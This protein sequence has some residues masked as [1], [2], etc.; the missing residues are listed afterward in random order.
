MSYVIINVCKLAPEVIALH[1]MRFNQPATAWKEGLPIGNGRLAAMI[2]GDKH[3]DVIALNHEWLW[4]GVNRD[5]KV[6]PNA[7]KLDYVRELLKDEKFFKATLFGNL[8]FG[9]DGGISGEQ[10]GVDPYQPAGDLIFSIDNCDSYVGRSLDIEHGSA[11]TSRLVEGC[12]VLSRFF[13]DCE[14]S[15]IY[16]SWHSQETFSGTLKLSRAADKYTKQVI[17]I[18]ANDSGKCII[19][20]GEFLNGISF[21]ITADIR[22]D[23]IFS[24]SE[25]NLK[26]ENA[27]WLKCIVNI[28][29]SVKG[30]KEELSIY[31]AEFDFEK[32]YT[33]HCDSFSQMFNR[34]SFEIKGDEEYNNYCMEDRIARIKKGKR[35]N[36]ISTLLYNFGRYL[37]IAS[38]ISGEL[39]PNL[40]GK[41]NDMAEPPW[42][43]DYHMNINL[44]MNHWLALPCQFNEGSLKF[45]TFLES[46]YDSAADAAKK[47][48]NCRGIYMPLQTDAWGISTPEAFGWAVWVGCAPWMA[49]HF[50]EHYTYNGDIG[51]LRNRAYPYFKKV[52]EFFEDYLVRDDNGVYQVMPSQS[53]ENRFQSSGLIPVSLCVSAAMDVQLCYD[54]FSYA[55]D[56]AQI[57]DIDLESVAIW[58]NIKNNLPKFGIGSD[59]RLLEWNDEKEEVQ[60]EL[61]HRHLSHLYG[62]YPSDL[63]TE[64]VRTAE[65]EASR[66]SFDFRL[67][68][69]G[70]H[71]GWSRAWVAALM[72][73]FN[74]P[75]GVY[76]HVTA[77]LVDFATVSLLD[78]H[79]PGWFQIDGNLGIVA[80]INDSLLS[81]TNDKIHVMRAVP[82]EWDCG[83][84]SGL[85]APGGHI[86]DLTWQNGK[87]ETLTIS[88][89]FAKKAVLVLSGEEKELTGFEGDIV[90]LRNTL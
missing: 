75:D 15:L 85:K 48:Y 29:T 6:V 58:K 36:G 88:I 60:E 19:L 35:D 64:N 13:A 87:M 67:K 30:I 55:I 12:N 14:S 62:V 33:M 81:F 54:A 5:R 63:F 74:N 61:G 76:E 51:F 21:C 3:K 31:T 84:I 82:K 90:V 49:R 45:L 4:R 59:G 89:G 73:R 72:S 57:L 9:G 46:F 47:L 25:S 16:C 42:D 80:A 26:I 44:Q 78:L 40:Q 86:I 50:W 28:A 68:H 17:K 41:W 34:T 38:T 7:D 39:P 24:D 43:S 18:S 77:L 83:S 27:T 56:A 79:P 69:G 10:A 37:F 23:G 53:P 1:I 8:Y 71:T 11:E 2:W 52:A 65:Y 66:K 32:V 20:D 70:G 22:T